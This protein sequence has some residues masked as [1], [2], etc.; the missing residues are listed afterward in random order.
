MPLRYLDAHGLR[1]ALSMRAA[2]ECLADAFRAAGAGQLLAP[3]RVHLKVG[4][5]GPAKGSP[6]SG[7]PADGDRRDHGAGEAPPVLEGHL[8]VMPAIWEGRRAAAVKVVSFLPRN[9]AAGRPA[10][11]GTALLLDVATGAPRLAVDAAGLTALRTGALVGLATSHLARQDARTV[12]I[13]GTGALAAD[14]VAGV[15]AVRPVERVVAYNRTR[16][17]AEALAGRL[18]GR[19]SLSTAVLASPEEVAA[20]SHVLVLATTSSEPVVDGAAIRPGTHINA[21]GNFSPGGRELGGAAVAACRRYVDDLGSALAEAGELILAA[22]EGLIPP[23]REGIVGDLADLVT[24]AVPGRTHPEER[25]LFKSVGTA[26]ADLAALLAAAEA[27]E[28]R[29][30]GAVLE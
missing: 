30:L 1:E 7:D 23:G 14:L 18:A 3:R 12:G 13:I 28:A 15:A 2:V 27:A 4:G 21:V 9:P 22:E 26:L 29:R 25:T 24:G 6:G 5:R 20:A 16:R 17:K 11:Q 8:L 10:L 19:G